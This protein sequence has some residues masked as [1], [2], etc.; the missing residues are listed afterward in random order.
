MLD[1][2]SPLCCSCPSMNRRV[3]LIWSSGERMDLSHL[4]P[5]EQPTSWQEPS[6][7]CWLLFQAPP[8][9]SAPLCRCDFTFTWD[10]HWGELGI[11]QKL[12]RATGTVNSCVDDADTVKTKRKWITTLHKYPRQGAPLRFLLESSDFHS[13]YTLT[14]AFS[15]RLP[16][17][18]SL[19]QTMSLK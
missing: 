9:D 17:S 6:K 14:V 11:H 4:G 3:K 2:S 12:Q 8:E 7:I 13:V 18:P 1:K 10:N 15:T 16:S 5:Q 19:R